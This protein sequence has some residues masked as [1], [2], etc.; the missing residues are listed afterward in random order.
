[1]TLPQKHASAF[2]S[3]ANSWYSRALVSFLLLTKSNFRKKRFIPAHNSR[4]QSTV[5]GST[6]A[7]A[8]RRSG[9]IHSQEQREMNECMHHTCLLELSL[10]S[11]LSCSSGPPYLENG[12]AHRSLGLPTSIKLIKTVSHM[13]AHRPMK[14][15]QGGKRK[16]TSN[17]GPLTCMHEACHTH[18]HTTHTK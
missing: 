14:H 4:W 18:K 12:T 6:E 11:P 3:S 5:L 15:S 17:S 9:D 1:M 10:I 16:L 8:G 2:F 13:R 7:E